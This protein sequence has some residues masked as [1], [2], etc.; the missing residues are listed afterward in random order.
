MRK[1]LKAAWQREAYSL[2]RAKQLI[3]KEMEREITRALRE[4]NDLN[5]LLA[6]IPLPATKPRI[7]PIHE[8]SGFGTVRRSEQEREG[9]Q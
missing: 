6:A 5:H 7:S 9:R 2:K 4:E 3:R 8:T 1:E